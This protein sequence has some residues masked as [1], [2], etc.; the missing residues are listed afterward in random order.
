MTKTC[1]KCQAIP[2]Y[3]V[4]QDGAKAKW[5]SC[6]PHLQRTIDEVLENSTSG[7]VV[8]RYG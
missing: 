2:R 4:Q 8:K 3:T 6:W 1:G 7:V 5:Y